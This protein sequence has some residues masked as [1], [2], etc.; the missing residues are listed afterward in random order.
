VSTVP[1]VPRR[2]NAQSKKQE[3]VAMTAVSSSD[4]IQNDPSRDDIA[5]LA[6]A[7]WESRGGLGGSAE[8]DWYRAEQEIRSRS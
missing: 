8:E 6:Y 5:K 2:G 1:R 7:L 3:A 4:P